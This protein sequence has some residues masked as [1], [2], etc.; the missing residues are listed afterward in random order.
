MEK[1]TIQDYNLLLELVEKEKESI[2]QQAMQN[3]ELRTRELELD[4]IKIKLNTLKKIEG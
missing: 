3:K 4:F 1:L 2:H